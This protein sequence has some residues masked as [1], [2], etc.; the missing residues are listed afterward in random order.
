VRARYLPLV[1]ANH[2]DSHSASEIE[3]RHRA[4][5]QITLPPSAGIHYQAGEGS[6]LVTGEHTPGVGCDACDQ[7]TLAW[8][9]RYMSM[10][11]ALSRLAKTGR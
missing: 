10:S 3:E 5:E 2:P 7:E 4:S 1:V 9:P 6:L 11:Y 8:N